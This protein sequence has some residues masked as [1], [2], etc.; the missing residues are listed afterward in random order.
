MKSFTRSW[1]AALALV[2][3]AAGTAAAQGQPGSSQ[4]PPSKPSYNP[5][6]TPPYNPGNTPPYNPGTNPPYNP[7]QNPPY[8]TN[9]NQG[10]NAAGAQLNQGQLLSGL[11]NSGNINVQNLKA[12]DLTDALTAGSIPERTLQ[13]LIH[14]L[15]ANPQAQ[16]AAQRLTQQLQAAKLL[17]EGAHVIGFANGKVYTLTGDEFKRIQGM[18]G[19]VGGTG[20]TPPGTGIGSGTGVGSGTG[21]GTGTGTTVNIT[22]NQLITS[23]TNINVNTFNVNNISARNVINLNTSNLFTPD[24]IQAIV[25]ALNSN[26]QALQN[27]QQLSQL[28]L[29]KR[30]IQ[31]GMMPV[32]FLNGNLYVVSQ[33]GTIK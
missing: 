30:L 18:A 9:P 17:P 19:A 5:G 8:N 12:S 20:I 28:L 27:A 2:A 29:A 33:N 24:Q 15:D 31:P 1:L 23:I 16:Q 14:L 7:G 13:Q 32:G 25:Q 26:P 10:G 4:P 11:I 22:Q 3:L 6:N 21:T